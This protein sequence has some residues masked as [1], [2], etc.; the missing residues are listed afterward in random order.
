MLYN[1]KSE[2]GP[3]ELPGPC[4]VSAIES[5]KDAR[6]ITRWNSRPFIRHTQAEPFALA[7]GPDNDAAL[8]ARILHRVIKQVVDHLLQTSLVHAQWRKILRDLQLGAE[9]FCGKG[10]FP[11]AHDAGQ[12]IFQS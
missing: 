8:G 4:F 6:Q 1:R 2:A 11:V 9:I 5:L 3:A 7:R 10:P 12:K